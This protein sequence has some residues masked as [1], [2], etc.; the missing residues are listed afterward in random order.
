MGLGSESLALGQVVEVGEREALGLRTLEVEVAEL[1]WS[2]S[3]K[4]PE[5]LFP[6]QLEP[7]ETE[8][9][10]LEVQGPLEELQSLILYLPTEAMVALV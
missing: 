2:V 9:A 7:E 8:A 10:P 4:C 3:T 5:P 6:I 1:Q